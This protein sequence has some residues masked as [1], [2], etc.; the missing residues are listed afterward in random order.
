MKKKDIKDFKT[1]PCTCC[2]GLQINTGTAWVCLK[3]FKKGITYYFNSGPVK[4]I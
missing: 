2:G 1:I 3:Q 4:F